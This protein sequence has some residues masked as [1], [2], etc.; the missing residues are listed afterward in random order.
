MA[1]SRRPISVIAEYIVI[2]VKHVNIGCFG[3]FAVER[4]G[5]ALCR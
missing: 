5:L 3:R 2:E 1:C 4:G